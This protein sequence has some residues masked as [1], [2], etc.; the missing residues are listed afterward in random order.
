M[1]L[2]VAL[3]T[4]LLVVCSLPSIAQ[5][6]KA[7]AMSPEEKAAMDAM[8]KAAT[9]G[10]EH[11]KLADMVGTWNA[12]TKM[13]NAPGMEPMTS[14]GVS[15]NKKVLGG[16]W[17]QQDYSGSFMGMPFNGIGYT[18]YDNV[19]KA[20]VGT[21]MDTFSTGVMTSK[22]AAEGNG[23][24]FTATMPDP[25]SGKDVETTEKIIVLSKD[26]HVMEMWMPGPDGNQF[27][28]MEITYTRK[29]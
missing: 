2:K 27:K 5:D 11:K 25:M 29:K 15:V 24:K 14:K 18:G 23:Y 20:Y 28:M 17:I 12:V 22:G 21:W 26:K 7:P 3:A 13:W 8:T 1:K 9:P 19:S 16:R 6:K 4:G 10:A